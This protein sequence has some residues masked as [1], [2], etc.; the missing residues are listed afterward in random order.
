MNSLFELL[1]SDLP[2]A[3]AVIVAG[4][5]LLQIEVVISFPTIRD[6]VS[7]DSVKFLL[8]SSA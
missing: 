3:L 6:T 1:N 4:V 2:L 8:A 7:C 5:I